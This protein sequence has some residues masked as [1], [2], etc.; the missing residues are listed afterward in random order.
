M[1][2]FLLLLR[3]CYESHLC[4]VTDQPVIYLPK[5]IDI[6]NSYILLFM[7][8]IVLCYYNFIR[9]K[10][11]DLDEIIKF[12]LINLSEWYAFDIWYASDQKSSTVH[13][14]ID[15]PAHSYNILP[16]KQPSFWSGCSQTAHCFFYWPMC[17]EHWLCHRK[18]GL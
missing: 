1:H 4:F 13:G 18:V 3:I 10:Y 6:G 12:T 14:W 8:Y 2:L 17:V 11:F 7:V 16:C 15:L 9:F 5:K